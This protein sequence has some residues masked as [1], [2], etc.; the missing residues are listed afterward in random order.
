MTVWY[1]IYAR[2]LE[3]AHSHATT[4]ELEL[5]YSVMLGKIEQASMEQVVLYTERLLGYQKY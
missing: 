1:E 2:M 3:T 5:K 4:L